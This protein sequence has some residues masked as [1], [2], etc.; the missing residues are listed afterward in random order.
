MTNAPCRD[1]MMYD[2]IVRKFVA[3]IGYYVSYM[4][5]TEYSS[6]LSIIFVCLF[7]GNLGL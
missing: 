3:L 6:S 2:I 5:N 7:R 4:M 1:W